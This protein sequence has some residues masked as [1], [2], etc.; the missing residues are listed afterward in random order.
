MYLDYYLFIYFFTIHVLGLLNGFST[1]SKNVF[2]L[3]EDALELLN[4]LISN[5]M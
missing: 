1:S 4:G 2:S 3:L 5:N